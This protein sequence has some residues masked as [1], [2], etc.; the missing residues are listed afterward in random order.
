[1][2]TAKVGVRVT[3][4]R[5][6]E[7][8][9]QFVPFFPDL[10]GKQ[11]LGIEVVKEAETETFRITMPKST[12]FA[13]HSHIPE[14]IDCKGL[15]AGMPSATILSM[16]LTHVGLLD[17]EREVASAQLIPEKDPEDTPGTETCVRP[18]CD[19]EHRTHLIPD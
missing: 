4:R 18:C 5:K 19:G 2:D 6:D 14:S 1:M 7:F 11:R 13:L 17:D 8:K 10:S 9:L 16:Y 15:R 12:L 3:L